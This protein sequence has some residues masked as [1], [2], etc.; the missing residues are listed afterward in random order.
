MMG[1]PPP[2]YRLCLMAITDRRITDN[3]DEKLVERCRLL[4]EAGLPSLMLREKELD[5]R[6]LYNLARQIRQFAHPRQTLFLVNDR[7]DVALAAGADGVH[8]GWTAVP[9]AEARRL[10]PPPFLIGVSCHTR[11]DLLHAQRDGADYAFLSPVFPPKSKASALRPLGV[12]GFA[13]AVSGLGLAVV[14]LGGIEPTHVKALREAG[15]AG[16]A[17]IGSFMA[18]PDATAAVQEFMTRIRA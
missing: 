7:L 4:C 5:G 16:V 12:Q 9:V 1:A 3:S 2:D 6:A 18:P 11:E 13:A 10:A 15:A 17:A 8:L 14:A